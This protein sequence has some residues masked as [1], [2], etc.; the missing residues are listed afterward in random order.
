MPRISTLLLLLLFGAGACRPDV[1][2]ARW[3]LRALAPLVETRIDINDILVDSTVSVGPD[4]LVSLVIRNKL[5]EAEAGEIAPPFNEVFVNSANIQKIELGRRTIREQVSLGEMALQAG[6]TGLLIIAG[7]GTNQVI[8]PLM[9][10]GPTSFPVDATE[11]FQSMTLRDGWLVLRMTNGFPIDLTNVQYEIANQG[12]GT[13]ILSNTIALFPAG[14]THIDSV[15]L[16]NNVTVTGQLVANLINIDSPGS[17]GNAVLI[18][19]SDQIDIQVTVDQLDP[20]AATAIFPAQELIK[21]T[22]TANISAPTAL[23]TSVHIDEGL[24]YMDVSSTIEDVINLRYQVP[25]AIRNGQPL[26]INETIPAAPPGG[27]NS[28]RAEVTVEDY[29]IDL[30]GIPGSVGVYNEFYT[31]FSGRVDSSGKLISLALVDSVYVETGIERMIADRGYGFL[32]YDSTLANETS[33]AVPLSSIIS[34]ELKLDNAILE[35]ELENYIGTE[36]QFAINQIRAERANLAQDLSWNEL[37]DIKLI[38]R[39]VENT[40]GQKPQPGRLSLNL[41]K[42]NS[43]IQELIELRPDSFQTSLE[44]YLNRNTSPSDFSQFLYV[45]YGL[46]AYLN[47]EIPLNLSLQDIE[48]ADTNDFDYRNLDPENRLQ[49]GVL[50]VLADNFYPFEARAELWLLDEKGALIDTLAPAETIAPAQ[51]DAEGRAVQLSSS[52]LNIPITPSDVPSLKATHQILFRVFFNTPG[53]PEK[54]KIY[55]DNYL[56]LKLV[57]DLSLNNR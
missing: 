9:G 13:A 2:P 15:R 23:L 19:T 24:I 12:G 39:A 45:D 49:H 34:G 41:D 43:N 55:S 27:S 28:K 50:K 6:T 51:V 52:Q 5:A 31:I 53:Q 42:S 21:D 38:P 56:D 57:G 54:V 14:S 11:F 16:N 3:E 44:Y 37:G 32:G 20:V 1:K 26:D 30:T 48:T 40:P 10:I 22:A 29:D 35:L 36:I 17:N 47:A 4:G 8:P 33:A 46:E 18:D 25:G 7:N